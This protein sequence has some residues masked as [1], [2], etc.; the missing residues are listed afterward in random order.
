MDQFAKAL[1]DIQGR[2]VIDQTGFNGVFDAHLEF[3]PEGTAFGWSPGVGV[4]KSGGSGTVAAP[5]RP[6]ISTAL[7]EQLAMRLGCAKEPV[8]IIVVDYT[9]RPIVN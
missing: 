9:E 8:E 6:L 1:T 3:T 5:D 2:P 7:Q 4:S